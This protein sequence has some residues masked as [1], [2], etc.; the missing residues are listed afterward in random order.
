[1]NGAASDA[2]PLA[3]GMPRPDGRTFSEQLHRIRD[4][5]IEVESILQS[6]AALQDDPPC[7]RCTSVCCKEVMC[8]ESIDSDFLRS[9]WTHGSMITASTPDGMCQAPDAGSAM[10]G[11]WCVTN[12]FASSSTRRI[13]RR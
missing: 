13:G 11:R 1:M 6:L 10:A 5:H 8:R 9:C 2:L 7:A 3:A 4:I 12:S